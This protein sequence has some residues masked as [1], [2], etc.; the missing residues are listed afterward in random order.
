MNHKKAITAAVAAAVILALGGT[1]V[2]SYLQTQK[3]RR[4]LEYSYA[5]SLNDLRD[6]VDSIS[7]TLDKAQYANTATEQNGLAAK[8]MSESSMAKAAIST[9]PLTDGPRQRHAVHHAGRRF[10]N[11]PREKDLGGPENLE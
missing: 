3:Y 11:V 1:A 10:F 2:F 5:R 8:L 7:T 4:E 6:S 9:L